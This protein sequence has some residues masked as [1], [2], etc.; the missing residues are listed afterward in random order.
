MR[1]R[2]APPPNPSPCP[3]SL[4]PRWYPLALRRRL[5]A[6]LC[7]AP[8]LLRVLAL[9]SAWPLWCSMLWASAL[10]SWRG[11]CRGSMLGRGAGGVLASGALVLCPGG[12]L[13]AGSPCRDA[14]LC[15]WCRCWRSAPSARSSPP[16]VSPWW[17]CPLPVLS[18]SPRC[19]GGAGSLPGLLFFCSGHGQ[20]VASALCLGISAGGG[21]VVV[22]LSGLAL[23]LVRDI[24]QQIAGLAVQEAAECRNAGKRDPGIPPPDFG[25]R[26]LRD[27]PLAQNPVRA[28]SPLPERLQD[29]KAVSDSA[30][31][32]PPF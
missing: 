4:P 30:H 2:P 7:G 3:H 16:G 31:K 32:I 25:H 5:C 8:S 17:G 15:R 29:V 6:P 13:S 1:P 14:S 22:R 24:L 19:V 28:D 10:L 9:A 11:W 12:A 18:L 27:Q 21:L 20:A 26:P 23:V